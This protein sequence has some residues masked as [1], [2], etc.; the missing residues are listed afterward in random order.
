[1]Q[2]LYLIAACGLSAASAFQA[3]LS[4][5]QRLSRLSPLAVGVGNDALIDLQETAQRDVY[6]MQNWATQCGAQTL[7]GFELTT[8]DGEDWSVVTSQSIPSGTPVLFIP[9]QMVL[10]SSDAE[11]GGNL[12]SA[13][14]ALKQYDGDTARIPLFRLMVKILLEYEQGAQSPFFPWLNSLPRRFFNGVAMT[15]KKR[16]NEDSVVASPNV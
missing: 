6:S 15:G 4:N 12:V 9:A 11:F 3:A 14:N 2:K 7:S 1:M 13:E 8:Q 16:G 5:R 10:S